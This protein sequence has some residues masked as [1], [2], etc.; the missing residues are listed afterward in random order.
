MKQKPINLLTSRF[1][2]FNTHKSKP[3]EQIGICAVHGKELI[4]AGIVK[5]SSRIS[6]KHTTFR[7]GKSGEKRRIKS[8]NFTEAGIL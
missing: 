7:A 1:I 4:M 5:G 6:R 2:G 3:S 8:K